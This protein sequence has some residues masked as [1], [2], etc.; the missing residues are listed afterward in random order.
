MMFTGGDASHL[1]GIL[2]LVENMDSSDD[3]WM[4]R[5]AS[6]LGFLEPALNAYFQSWNIIRLRVRKYDSN[7]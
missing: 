3:A 7:E 4:E 5:Q 1:T 6:A 2:K